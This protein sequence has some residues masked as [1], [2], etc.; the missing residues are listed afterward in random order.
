MKITINYTC[1]NEVNDIKSSFKKFSLLKLTLEV[2]CSKKSTGFTSIVSC[3]CD[4]SK[5]NY[6][7]KYI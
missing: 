1:F 4:W 2:C 3:T 6:K 7:K 5:N